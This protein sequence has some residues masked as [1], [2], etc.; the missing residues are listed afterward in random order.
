MRW[1]GAAGNCVEAE[2][3]TFCPLE[4]FLGGRGSLVPCSAQTVLV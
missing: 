2:L 3:Q 1:G 4:W